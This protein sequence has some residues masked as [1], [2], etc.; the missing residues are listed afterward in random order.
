MSPELDALLDRYYTTIPRQERTGVLGEIV[1]HTTDRLTLM[2]L[3]Y[4]AEPLMI[5]SRLVG[6]AAAKAADS[7]PGWNAEQWDLK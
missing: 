1:R 2:G 3:F 7:S 4:D 6:V 5:G